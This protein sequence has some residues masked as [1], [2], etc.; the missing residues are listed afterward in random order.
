MISSKDGSSGSGSG[1]GSG[2]FARGGG[3]L[4]FD[5]NSL[6]DAALD[7]DDF[8]GA[9]PFDDNSLDDAGALAAGD[10][11]CC[12]V[13]PFDDNDLDDADLDDDDL[14]GDGLADDDGAGAPCFCA[15]RLAKA[16]SSG[17][18]KAAKISGESACA[19]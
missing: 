17:L 5:D 6:D 12:G 9:L 14:A 10:D 7:V 3:A 16:L 2:D 13:F 18:F 19:C 8:C 1:S 11:L 4:A 15:A